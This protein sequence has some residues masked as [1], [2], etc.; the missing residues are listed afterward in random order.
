MAETQA[1]FQY[2]K[3][4]IKLLRETGHDT[5]SYSHVLRQV[6]ALGISAKEL[7][8]LLEVLMAQ[9]YLALRSQRETRTTGGPQEL[10]RMTTWWR[11]LIFPMDLQLVPHP[12]VWHAARN[13]LEKGPEGQS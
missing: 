9:G 1:Q 12:K 6:R 13:W 2:A 5:I 8:A 11:R 7:H 4:I 10:E 3:K